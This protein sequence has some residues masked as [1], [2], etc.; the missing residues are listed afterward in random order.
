[1]PPLLA[2]NIYANG[3]WS[4]KHQRQERTTGCLGFGFTGGWVAQPSNAPRHFQTLQTP[5]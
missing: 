2:Q 3:P 5:R 1:V 4:K